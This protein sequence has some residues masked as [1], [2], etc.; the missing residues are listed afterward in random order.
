[1]PVRPGTVS[2]LW[3][4]VCPKNAK[5]VAV[6]FVRAD[7][8]LYVG[9]LSVFTPRHLYFVF[10]LPSPPP[11]RP[12]LMECCRRYVQ[13]FK[14]L[15]IKAKNVSL[16][17]FCLLGLLFQLQGSLQ[18]AHNNSLKERNS[19]GQRHWDSLRLNSILCLKR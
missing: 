16:P 4:S 10:I 18:T 11:S 8:R 17:T 5:F 2:R 15:L 7:L 6:C 1:M 19:P 12:P 3:I 13:L 9:P 14:L